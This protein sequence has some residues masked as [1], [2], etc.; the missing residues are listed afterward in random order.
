MSQQPV[1]CFTS[2]IDWA[3][4][5]AIKQILQYFKNA[6]IPLTVFLTHESKTL[7]FAIQSGEIQAGIHPNFLQG[8]SQ[9]DS[10]DEVIDFCFDL[11]PDAVGFRSHRYF[12]VNDVYEKLYSRGIRFASNT[13]TVL[14]NIPPF[15]HRNGMVQFPVFF[16]DGAY[17]WQKGEMSFKSVERIFSSEGL[18]VINIHP[19]HLMLNTPYFA[20]A[21]KIKD[22]VSKEEWN[23]FDEKAIR[24]MRSAETGMSNFIDE[25]IEFIKKNN[26]QVT[27]LNN[28][29]KKLL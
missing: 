28:I 10:F 16:E 1:F 29:Y 12:E 6:D 19:M 9:G 14:E 18:K 5:F 20:Y 24:R 22:T 2:D 3:S 8:S 11:L 4:E 27:C 13:C 23:S 26:I 21:R 25:M 15:L 17:L 7:D